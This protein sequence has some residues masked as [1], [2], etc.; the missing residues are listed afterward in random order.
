MID[1]HNITPGEMRE[2]AS[3]SGKAS[4]RRPRFVKLGTLRD[5]T[6]HNGSAKKD[7]GS[8]AH[9]SFTGRGGRNGGHRHT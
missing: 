9:T 8:G 2:A 7:G 4:Y 3:A 6:R 5:L 1:R